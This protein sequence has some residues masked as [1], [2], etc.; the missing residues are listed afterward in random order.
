MSIR[1]LTV[2]ALVGG[3]ALAACKKEEAGST[4]SGTSAA[5]ATTDQGTSGG[6]SGTTSN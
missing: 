5:P 4:T 3:L 2:L 1:I 6:T